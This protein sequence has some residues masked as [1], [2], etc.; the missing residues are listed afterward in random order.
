[1]DDGCEMVDW[2]VNE[3]VGLMDGWMDECG[4]WSDGMGW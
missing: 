1:M 3:W 2:W 4:G